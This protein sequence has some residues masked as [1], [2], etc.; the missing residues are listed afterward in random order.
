MPSPIDLL[1]ESLH[2]HNA[3]TALKIGKNYLSYQL[4]FDRARQLTNCILEEVGR[5]F[6]IGILGDRSL[7]VYLGTLASL[8]LGVTFVPLHKIFL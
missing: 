7:S 2:K 5:P 6:R 1:M 4:L 3:L 8:L